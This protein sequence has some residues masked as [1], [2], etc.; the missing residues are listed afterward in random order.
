MV[1]IIQTVISI[2]ATVYK[3]LL[4]FDTA[5]FKTTAETG[6]ADEAL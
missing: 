3:D 5:E 2:C 4:S 6:I 1:R